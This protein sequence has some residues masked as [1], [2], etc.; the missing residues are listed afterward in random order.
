[1]DT[2]ILT[3]VTG[4]IGRNLLE[5]LVSNYTV[6][7]IVRQQPDFELP[8]G[9]ILVLQDLTKPLITDQLPQRA[10]Y[11]IHLAQSRLYRFFPEEAA[12]IF[13]INIKSTFELLEY[14]RKAKIKN[15]IYASTG[16]IYGFGAKPS[17][18]DAHIEIDNLNFYSSSKYCAEMIIKSYKKYFNTILLRL[19]FV[20][21]P[22]QKEML[23]Y[24]LIQKVIDGEDIVIDGEPGLKIT[25]T[26][27]D[28]VLNCF[29]QSLNINTSEVINI[30]GNETVSL[31][32]LVK[33]IMS[34]TGNK[35]KIKYR[36]V[37][38][39]GDIISDNCY[40]K[41][42]FKMNLQTCLKEGLE[43]TVKKIIKKD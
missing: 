4:F 39:K 9:V 25:P 11:I 35:I 22:G 23:I 21:G 20:Y 27:I 19:F 13:D 33:A 2:I 12:D 28:D 17:V 40:M 30:S 3:G 8:A 24:S 14:G 26:Y 1:M 34:E 29:E 7:A 15:F 41:K 36:D 38:Y 43:K 32:E 5:R 31:T 37:E 10:D 18:E 16:S 6:Y 42:I